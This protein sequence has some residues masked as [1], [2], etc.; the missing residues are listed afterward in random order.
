MAIGYFHVISDMNWLVV[1]RSDS[2][3][4]SSGYSAVQAIS[5]LISKGVP[6]PN[7][8]F[9]NLISVSLPSVREVHFYRRAYFLSVF[10]LLN[11]PFLPHSRHLKAFM[12]C[13]NVF[14]E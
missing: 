11:C 4:V 12:W 7:I 13:A 2:L 6:E 10:F 9:L 1:S 14:Q 5:L 8:I 3:D